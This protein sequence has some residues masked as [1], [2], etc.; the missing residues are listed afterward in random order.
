MRRK[1]IPVEWAMEA[2]GEDTAYRAAH[3]AL[4]GE[5]ALVPAMTE[6]RRGRHGGATGRGGDGYDAPG[7][8]RRRRRC[9]ARVSRAW[10]LPRFGAK[11]GFRPRR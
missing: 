2:R 10:S 1:P 4:E 3:D 11:Q 7:A 8:P 9:R 6:A 5:F